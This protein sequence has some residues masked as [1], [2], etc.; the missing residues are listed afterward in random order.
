MADRDYFLKIDGIDGESADSKHKGEIDIDSFS[1]GVSNAGSMA[2]GGGG[3]SGRAHFQDVTVTKSVDKSSAKL[4]LTCASGQHIKK[5][6]LTCRKAGGEQ[7]EYL[8]IT[9]EDLLISSFQDGGG[10]GG[11]MPSESL[12]INYAKI[13]YDYTPQS[14]TGGAEG[15]VSAA[16]DVRGNVKA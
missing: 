10:G 8:V 16:W 5:A 15:K 12:S 4:M 14:A 7:M 11:L 1:F 13:S 2:I 6:V 3:G 9:M